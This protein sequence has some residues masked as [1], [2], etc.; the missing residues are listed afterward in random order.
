M[1]L[2]LA[3]VSVHAVAAPLELIS[4]KWGAG[5]RQ[6][7]ATAFAAGRLREGKFLVLSSQDAKELG[8]PAPMTPKVLTATIKVQGEE[9]TLTVGEYSAPIIIRVGDYPATGELTI[10]SATYGSGD[11]SKDLREK[12][13]QMIKEN[14][15][16]NV[17][18]DFA[19]ADPAPNKAKELVIV[20]SV[21][22]C[23][24]AMIVPEGKQFNPAGLK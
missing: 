8:D 22:N 24:R 15:T 14:K 2:L 4:A 17:N 16:E 7:D 12:V 13:G 1:L 23:F 9:R 10:Y 6:C 3:V 11:K 20:Y 19:G 21:D 18:N 5:D